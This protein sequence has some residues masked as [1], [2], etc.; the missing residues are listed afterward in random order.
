MAAVN[1]SGE[2]EAPPLHF[3]DFGSDD[4]SEDTSAADTR[5]LPELRL[6][7]QPCPVHARIAQESQAQDRHADTAVRLAASAAMSSISTM[8]PSCYPF[9]EETVILGVIYGS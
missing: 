9:L 4:E 1:A 5:A 3:F 6:V 2:G 8:W 7:L